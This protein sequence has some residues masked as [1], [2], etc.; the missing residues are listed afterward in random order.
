M[1]FEIIQN[2]IRW[3][4]LFHVVCGA[5]ALGV[6][7]IPLLSKKG[8]KLHIK[9]G[10]LY[11]YAMVFV[12]VS[13]FIITP[14]RAFFDEARTSSSIGFSAFLF[15]I[16][17]FTLSSLWNGLRVLKFKKRETS[18]TELAQMVPPIILIVLGLATQVLGY[19]L[20]NILLMTFPFLS[21]FTAKDQLKY[22]L[23]SPKE[24]MHW[25]YFHMNGMFAAC[26]ATVT[27]FLVTAIPR[28]FPGNAIAESPILWIAPGVILGIVLKKWTMSF[29]TQFG[30]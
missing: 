16:A 22:W 2:P 10:W 30:D 15:F 28:V 6:F 24:K 29:R 14:W 12:G 9:V 23:S 11:T 5:V 13:A 4:I 3:L 25:W 8:G 17:A 7:M 27:A 19:F 1:K 21:H 20:N 26:I 18:N